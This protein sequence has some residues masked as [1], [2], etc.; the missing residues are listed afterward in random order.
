[1]EPEKCFQISAAANISHPIIGMVALMP[2]LPLVYQQS[3]PKV[4][5]AQLIYTS[6]RSSPLS[7]NVQ[8]II[9]VEASNT[10]TVFYPVAKILKHES[11]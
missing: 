10:Q 9:N 7:P 1:M 2:C 6:Y 3:F 8:I 11:N 5:K 4:D